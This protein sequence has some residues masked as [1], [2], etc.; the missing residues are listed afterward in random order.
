MHRE[1]CEYGRQRPGTGRATALCL[2]SLRADIEA[3]VVRNTAQ[4]TLQALGASTL[5]ALGWTSGP[6]RRAH[7]PTSEAAAIAAWGR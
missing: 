1:S 3:A 7:R 5:A 2:R 4:T 6:S